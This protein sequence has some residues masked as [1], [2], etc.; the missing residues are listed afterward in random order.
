MRQLRLPA[1]VSAMDVWMLERCPA[2]RV[3]CLSNLDPAMDREMSKEAQLHGQP[4]ASHV[5]IRG[6]PLLFISPWE[7]ER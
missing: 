5:N 3:H 6:N 2:L 4:D 1:V 7:L